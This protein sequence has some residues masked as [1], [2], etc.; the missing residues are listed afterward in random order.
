MQSVSTLIIIR[1]WAGSKS[2]LHEHGRGLGLIRVLIV[3]GQ[4]EVRRGL[5]MRLSIEADMEI[6]GETGKTGEALYL[7]QAQRPDVILVDFRARG[8]EEM[9]LIESLRKVAPA[10]AVVVLTLRG[11][12]DTRARAY[13]AGAQAF[14]EKCGGAADLLRTIRQQAK[15]RF[16]RPTAAP[17][18]ADARVRARPGTDS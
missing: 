11:D 6:A 14:L 13:Q 7:A 2:L 15:Q 4:D 10:A 3:D 12:D 9:A 5:R 8:S 17:G 16:E 18:T 1:A